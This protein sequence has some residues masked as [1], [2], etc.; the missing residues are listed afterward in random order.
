MTGPVLVTGATG[1]VGAALCR[2]LRGQGRKV[3]AALR[4]AG[5]AL[6]EGVEPRVVGEIGPDTDWRS[7][8]EGVPCVV[9]AAA[10]VH[11]MREAAEDP[12]AAY[13]RVNTYGTACLAEACAAAGVQRLV[14][15]S[16]IKAMGDGT[17][18]GTAYREDQPCAPTDAYGRS[19]AEAEA[20]LAG[21]AGGRLE[22][23]ILRPPLVYGPGARGN[24]PALL[25]LCDTP[26]PLPLGGID[27]RRSLLALDNLV[28]AVI[29]AIDHPAAA[30]RLF[31]LRD[32]ED[33][34]TSALVARLRR[35]LGRPQRLIALPGGAW[36]LLRRL[37][38]LAGAVDRLTGSLAVDDAA[39][40]RDLGW[41]PPVA[42]DRALA[43]VA[44]A[45][46]RRARASL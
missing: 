33:L 32:G 38:P 16:S 39:I 29:R 42:V 23:V 35:A 22:T 46:R 8:L 37:G 17:A 21:G 6:P 28:D 19:K 26:W 34:S 36:R 9:H 45:W 10:R 13:R 5:A 20:A 4:R 12:L 7:A 1:F 3:A 14:F 30:G 15:L 24:F 40:R 27:N 18:A 11:H 31:L 41:R 44:A 43:E 2:A 25:R